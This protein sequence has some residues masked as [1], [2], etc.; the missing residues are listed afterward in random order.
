MVINEEIEAD[1]LTFVTKYLSQG[2]RGKTKVLKLAKDSFAP[3]FADVAGQHAA[4]E[5]I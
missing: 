5:A 1:S 2:C 3:T 4:D